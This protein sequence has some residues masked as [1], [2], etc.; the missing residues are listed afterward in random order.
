MDQKCILII[1]D[2]KNIR[3]TL[4]TCL[5]SLNYRIDTAVNGEEGVEKARNNDY[6]LVF[7]DMK[8]PGMDGLTTLKHLKQ[9][10]PALNVIM[11]TAYGTIESAV[12]AMKVGAVDYIRK[13]FA[14]EEIKE[15]IAVVVKRQNL[16]TPDQDYDSLVEY[17]KHL[18]VKQD[19]AEAKQWLS[20]AIA[21]ESSQPEAFY[22]LGVLA[23][24]GADLPQAKK[25]YRAALSLDPTHTMA[26]D[27]LHRLVEWK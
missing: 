21:L 8:M 16:A 19:F 1:D 22:L 18:L 3:L 2:E 5:E 14:P 15:I 4:E 12:E 27:N 13:P 6:F 24:L 25:M 26:H 23:E 9:I 17:A 7:L 10:H 11:M 20:K